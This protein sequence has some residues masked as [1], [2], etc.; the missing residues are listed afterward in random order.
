MNLSPEALSGIT[1]MLG[2]GDEPAPELVA[3]P[4]AEETQVQADTSSDTT[5]D[6]NV[7][8]EDGADSAPLEASAEDSHAE[9]EDVPSGHRVPYDRFK[10]VLESRNQF[11]EERAG[12][13]AEIE[14]LRSQPATAPAP[15]QAAPQ[16]DSDDAWLER[17][18]AGDDEPAPAQDNAKLN[19]FQERLYNTEVQLARQQLE[20]EVGSA[21]QKFPTV[22]RDVIL[23]AVANN[24]SATAEAVA[25][26]YSS[27]VAGVEEKAISAY[28]DK[29][30]SSTPAD[31]VD[32][33]GQPKAA[34]RPRTGGGNAVVS[35][36]EVPL[37]SISEG[38]AALR[39]MWARNNPF[40]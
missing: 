2:A 1:N 10:Q 28:L 33:L 8:V 14:R 30:P 17:Y 15:V 13:E 31:A 16:A 21:L 37:K 9:E 35:A 32:A 23:Q 40:A 29:N 4:V 22:P 34:P 36:S 5:E 6:V 12:L 38:S 3:A 24:P 11:R 27:W 18:L 20:V 26:Q 7:N 25:E 39:K 19:E